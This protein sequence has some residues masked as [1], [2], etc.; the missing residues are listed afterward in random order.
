MHKIYKITNQLNG[1][2]Y[3]GIT[4][5]EIEKRW[6]KHVKDSNMPFYPLHCEIQEYGKENFKIEVIFESEDARKVSDL[7][8]PMIELYNSHISKNGYN[9]TKGRNLGIAS[10]RK[11]PWI[12][13]DKTN[14]DNKITLSV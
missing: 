12:A 9:L 2:S 14:V 8:Q 6:E 1:K 3:I 4:T 5:S 11:G 13:K 10:N 7:E